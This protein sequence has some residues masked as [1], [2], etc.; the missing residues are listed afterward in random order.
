MNGTCLLM[1]YYHGRKMATG[2]G[3]TMRNRPGVA[4]LLGIL[5]LGSIL[6]M[7]SCGPTVD[8]TG[9]GIGGNTDTNGTGIG[10]VSGFGSV[11]LNGVK[12]GDA[13]ID[14]TNFFAAV[15]EGRT[16]VKARGTA[17]SPS[18]FMTANEL[19][20]QPAIDN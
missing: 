11:I 20:V 19:Q 5:A 6:A 13:G 8:L 14:N 4:V 16:V 12:Y 7:T 1:L 10:P 9:L 15:I 17:G 2:R 18:V 3:S